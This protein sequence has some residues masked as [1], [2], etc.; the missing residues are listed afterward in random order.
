MKRLFVEACANVQTIPWND[1]SLYEIA[2]DALSVT[3]AP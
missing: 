1:H 3:L 2:L